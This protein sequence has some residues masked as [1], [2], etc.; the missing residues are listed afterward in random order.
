MFELK[1]WLQMVPTLE[2]NISGN[3]KFGNTLKEM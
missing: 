3:N 2:S 1:L